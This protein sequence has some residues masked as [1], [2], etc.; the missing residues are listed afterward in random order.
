ML[1]FGTAVYA[2]RFAYFFKYATLAS[3]IIKNYF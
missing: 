3:I 2:P 1:D